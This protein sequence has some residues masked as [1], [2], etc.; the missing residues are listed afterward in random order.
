MRVWATK[1]KIGPYP[2]HVGAK[3]KAIHMD[4]AQSRRQHGFFGLRSLCFGARELGG[5]DTR[6]GDRARTAPHSFA[7]QKKGRGLRFVC[8]CIK[9][10]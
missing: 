8:W 6:A 5:H 4:L 3:S 1:G 7:L 10:I 2:D 9:K